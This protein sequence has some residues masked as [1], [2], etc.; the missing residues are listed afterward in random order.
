MRHLDTPNLRGRTEQEAEYTPKELSEK[1]TLCE[2]HHGRRDAELHEEFNF[3]FRPPEEAEGSKDCNF[4]EKPK[5]TEEGGDEANKG[6]I[7]EEKLGTANSIKS[8]IESDMFDLIIM[9]DLDT[10]N[11]IRAKRRKG[12]RRTRQ[13][14]NTAT[15]RELRRAF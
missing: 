6:E 3:D 13:H 2:G 11:Q 7:T 9:L 14:R 15:A 4:M 1:C 5:I 8:G 12:Q 10:P